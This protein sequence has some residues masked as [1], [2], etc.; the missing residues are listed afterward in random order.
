MG[1]QLWFGD[2]PRDT[3]TEAKGMRGKPHWTLPADWAARI[4][5]VLWLPYMLLNLFFPGP[6]LTY[7]LGLSIALLALISLKLAHVP[8]IGIYPRIPSR[9]SV[10]ALAILTLFIPLALLIGRGQSWDWLGNM[11]YAPASA[12]GQELYFRSALLTAFGRYGSRRAI[13]LQATLFALWH[14]RAFR[15]VPAWEALLVL[16]GTF[17]AGIIWGWQVRK[18]NTTFYA[19]IQHLL[20]L[21]VQ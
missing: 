18:D 16:L 6:V 2:T 4:V 10:V 12:L 21:I 11:V 19:F 7:A 8:A 15:I 1:K 5:M 13:L 14:A 17:I 20:F 9:E 3:L